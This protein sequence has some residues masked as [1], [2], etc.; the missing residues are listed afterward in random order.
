MAVHISSDLG[1]IELTETERNAVRAFL[2]RAEVRMSTMHRI[3]TAF[4]SGAGLL[5]LIPVFLRD[6]VDGIS[7]IL[8]ENLDNHF[9]Q[10]G[11]GMGWALTL[12]LYFLL[13]YPFLLSLAIPLY[14][15]YLLLKDLVHFYYTL[16]MP[17]FSDGLLNP[18]LSLYGLTFA[19]DESPVVKRAI[20][21]FQYG[22]KSRANLVMPFS[23]ARRESYFDDIVAR[24]EG[25]ILPTT[26]TLAALH[27]AGIVLD[28][29]HAA[30]QLSTTFG[31]ARSLDRAL[32]EEAALTEM[33]MARNVIY[34][35]RLLV[36]YVKTLLMF[37]WTT[38]VAFLML[39]F[40]EHNHLS[41]FIVLSAG[42]LVWS[43]GAMPVARS[44]VYWIYRHRRRDHHLMHVDAQLTLLDRRIQPFVQLAIVVSVLGFGLALYQ[45]MA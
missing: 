24:T 42:Y 13:L 29:E 33:L 36:R 41:A 23:E 26:R 39:P 2:G 22:D 12:L 6:V 3:V 40:L 16:Y 19:I 32:V 11:D 28:D 7:L 27:D 17:G 43:V 45:I 4:I 37:L 38:V 25:R 9:S 34:L 15:V 35:R 21:Q 44:P 5:L 8:L 14:G 18:T 1:A 30:E 10:F 20:W 31:M